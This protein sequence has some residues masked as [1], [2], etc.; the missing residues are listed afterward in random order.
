VQ[1]DKLSCPRTVEIVHRMGKLAATL[2]TIHTAWPKIAEPNRAEVLM[3]IAAFLQ[4]NP[5]INATVLGES[6]ARFSPDQLVL[7]AKAVA[8]ASIERRLWVHFYEQVVQA[9]NYGRQSAS[10]KRV[11]R[12][13]ISPR[14][15]KM[16][17][18]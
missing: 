17:M 14:A 9:F 13:E 3:G 1:V 12:L 11:S 8:K 2:L 18:S 4:V 16:W 7:Q 5:Q 6:L 15:P 10:G